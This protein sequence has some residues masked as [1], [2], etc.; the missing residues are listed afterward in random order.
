MS[1][2]T[3]AVRL[4]Y[5]CDALAVVDKPAGL[6]SVSGLGARRR[7]ACTPALLD[8]WLARQ[9]PRSRP[10]VFP[11]VAALQAALQAAPAAPPA[12][13]PARAVPAS[14][15]GVRGRRRLLAAGALPFIAS[16]AAYA[17]QQAGVVGGNARV[18]DDAAGGAGLRSLLRVTPRA[19]HRL[20]EATSGLQLLALTAPV[21]RA[22]SI[23]FEARTLRKVYEAVLDTRALEAMAAAGDGWAQTSAL[24]SADAGEVATPLCARIDEPL[25]SAAPSLRGAAPAWLVSACTELATDAVARSAGAAPLSAPG[26]V[27]RVARE[28]ADDLSAL[29]APAHPP[30]SSLSAAAAAAAAAKPSLTRWRVLE[31]LPGAVRVEFEPHTGRTHQLRLHAALPPPLGLG[32]PVLGDHFYGDEEHVPDSF[33]PELLRRALCARLVPG[34]GRATP[35]ASTGDLL[36]LAAAMRRRW[37][38]RAPNS[39]EWSQRWPNLVQMRDGGGGGVAVS[40]LFLHARELHVP[41]HLIYMV[42]ATKAALA[43]GGG[44]AE[45]AVAEARRRQPRAAAPARQPLAPAAAAPSCLVGGSSDGDADDAATTAAADAAW[46]VV[47]VSAPV[48]FAAA[49]PLVLSSAT[50][51]SS[52]GDRQK[53]AGASLLPA[54]AAADHGQ[55]PRPHIAAL[56]RA[57]AN[58][59]GSPVGIAWQGA[60]LHLYEAVVARVRRRVVALVAESPF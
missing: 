20:D 33:A 24:L 53:L 60:A 18:G 8:R 50:T 54:A 1:Q 28:T 55:G 36:L 5:L 23:A 42:A 41:D 17:R 31:R 45:P 19:V 13:Q 52:P 22:L 47:D 46:P 9:A 7:A 2:R 27:A 14:D 51:D 16:A 38:A 44:E 29:V 21:H 39:T 57:A 34:P 6:L 40:R 3:S 10:S 11:S 49:V 32:A 30:P 4:L 37:V 59:A 25:L 15:L 26:D 56:L 48:H 35:A 12:A 43:L 58:A